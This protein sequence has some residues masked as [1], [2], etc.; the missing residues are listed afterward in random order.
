MEYYGQGEDMLEVSS[1]A[2]AVEQISFAATV[3]GRTGSK[4]EN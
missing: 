3:L 1:V 2:E 4:L